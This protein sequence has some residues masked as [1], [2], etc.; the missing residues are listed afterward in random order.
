[1]KLPILITI[2]DATG[3][4]WPFEKLDTFTKFIK[5][6]ERF[7]KEKQKESE[8]KGFAS[9]YLNVFSQLANI[10]VLTKDIKTMLS[11]GDESSTKIHLTQ[12]QAS[13]L[14]PLSTAWIWSGQTFI[15]SWLDSYKISQT[16]GDTFIQIILAQN[17]TYTSL[18]SY[19]YFKG[20]LLAY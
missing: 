5:E 18:S 1:M 10:I 20:C 16:T 11:S 15:T 3:K 9:T 7:W 13:Q 8:D 12:F 6:E 2:S 17:I 4:S 19:D 14:N